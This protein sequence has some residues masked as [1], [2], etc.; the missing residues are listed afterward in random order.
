MMVEPLLGSSYQLYSSVIYRD[1]L[2]MGHYPSGRVFEFNGTSIRDIATSLPVPASVSKSAR[3]AQTTI[4]YGGE[5]FAE[6]A[7]TSAAS[8]QIWPVACLEGQVL[9]LREVAA[10]TPVGYGASFVAPTAMRIATIGL[11]YADGL[12]RLLSNSGSGFIAG[13]KVPIVGRVSMDLTCVDVSAATV[14]EGDWVEFF[15]ANVALGDVARQAQTIDY[16]ILCGIG[17]RVLRRYQAL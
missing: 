3:E 1:H 16:E 10:G 5:V 13:H 8:E 14:A 15:G 9:Q 4:L 2:L 11:G 17:A 7:Q 12:P 6:T